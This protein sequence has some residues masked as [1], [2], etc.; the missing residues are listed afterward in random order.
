MRD[1]ALSRDLTINALF[2]D[3]VQNKVRDESGMGLN[4]LKYL[5][6]TQLNFFYRVERRG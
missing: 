4:D 3:I 5:F 2:Y 1:D 6:S